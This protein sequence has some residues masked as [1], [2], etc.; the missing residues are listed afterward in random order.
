MVLIFN[1]E[2]G[3]TIFLRNNGTFLQQYTVSGARIPRSEPRSNYHV[4]RMMSERKCSSYALQTLWR[5]VE[6]L[7]VCH[8]CHHCACQV[9][10]QLTGS[11]HSELHRAGYAIRS[12]CYRSLNISAFGAMSRPPD[13]ITNSRLGKNCHFLP[14]FGTSKGEKYQ[15]N[16]WYQA[17]GIR[18]GT[19]SC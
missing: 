2:D 12:F 19:F 14:L 7:E 3:G 4:S 5:V 6:M 10:L 1:T 17:T 15:R 13:L 9:N 18:N 8:S 16:I 11:S